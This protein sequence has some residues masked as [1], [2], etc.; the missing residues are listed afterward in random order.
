MKNISEIK[1]YQVV[2]VGLSVALGTILSAFIVSHAVIEFQKLQSQAITVT[3][4]ASQKVT[5][6]FAVWTAGFEARNSNLKDGYSKLTSDA[7]TIKDYLLS[8]G[9]DESAIEFTPVNSYAMYQRTGSGY[10]T[11]FV[12]GYRL[13]QNVKVSS[14]DIAKITAISKGAGSLIDKDVELSSNNLQYFV[15]NLDD[16]KI[17]MVGEATKNAKQRAQSMVSS[18]NGKIGVMNSAKMGVFQIVPDNSTE[19]SDYGIN[20]TTSVE[21]KVTAVVNATFTVK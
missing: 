18:T 20:D 7:K 5:S 6:D 10:E 1:D 4:S 16:I 15:S 8:N 9:V 13:S 14:K 21:K 3:G 12:D 17:K 11:N 19:I 2:L